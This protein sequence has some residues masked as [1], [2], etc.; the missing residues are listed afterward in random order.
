MAAKFLALWTYAQT[1]FSKTSTIVSH[2]SS[3]GNIMQELQSIIHV[4]EK[5]K[6][7][8]VI[9]ASLAMLHR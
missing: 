5:E 6:Q 1:V 4:K 9:I 7:P 2:I 8:V 3:V